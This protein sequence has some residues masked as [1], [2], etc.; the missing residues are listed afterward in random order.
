MSEG[1]KPSECRCLISSP[2][3]KKTLSLILFVIS[4]AAGCFHGPLSSEEISNYSIDPQNTIVIWALSDIQPKNDIQRIEFERAIEDVNTNIKDIDFALVAGDIVN[5][6]IARVYEWYVEAKK[7]SYIKEWYEIAG[8]HDLKSDMGELYRELVN[9][10]FYYQ[11]TKGNILF[12][13]M[14]DE[15]RGSP[16]I[17]SDSTFEWWKGLVERNQDKIIVV[18]THA[19]LEGSGIILSV[20]KRRQIRDSERFS[21]VLKKYKV[22]MWLNGHIHVP[23]WFKGTVGRIEELGS[24]IFVSVGTI[25]T[26][27]LG[28]KPSESRIISFVCG[29]DEVLIRSRNHTKQ[30]YTV[31]HDSVFKL[32]KKVECEVAK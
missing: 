22:D 17:I 29:S 13:L 2:N 18:V 24:T 5:R 10:D 11:F 14:S 27:G 25:R 32:S 31:Q 7:S 30:K 8:N 20:Q 3:M 15:E 19:P 12:I 1:R 16:T 6:T 4:S 21:K 28:L 23:H 9:K 26:E